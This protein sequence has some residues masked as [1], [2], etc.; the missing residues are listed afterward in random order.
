MVKATIRYLDEKKRRIVIPKEVTEVEDLH[1]G[2]FIEI[3]VRKIE[4]TKAH[5]AE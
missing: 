4:K 2:D 1:S 5:A 3:D